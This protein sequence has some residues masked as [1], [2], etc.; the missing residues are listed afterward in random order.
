MSSS[1]SSRALL[2]S[3]RGRVFAFGN[4]LAGLIH[5]FFFWFLEARAMARYGLQDPPPMF[6]STT[7]AASSDTFNP[8]S[9]HDAA[10]IH[11]DILVS[12]SNSPTRSS[13]TP[14]HYHTD[15]NL[16]LLGFN[17][18]KVRLD[19]L[20][21]NRVELGD[22]L[23]R[24]N[25]R[26]SRVLVSSDSNPNVFTVA[27]SL[28]DAITTHDTATSELIHD[29]REPH[30]LQ[31]ESKWSEEVK[32]APP[33]VDGPPWVARWSGVIIIVVASKYLLL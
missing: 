17:L 27:Q 8:I 3:I 5:Y 6:R 21:A 31:M 24:V 16:A 23:E 11:A 9:T 12:A 15:I 30:R 25:R 26:E 29:S 2:D 33:P 20:G 1:V 14:N 10:I 4:K 7:V 18:I 19:L 28:K 13:I 22:R 32:L